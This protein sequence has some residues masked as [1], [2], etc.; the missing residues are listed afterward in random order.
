[1][2]RV[3]STVYCW[4]LVLICKVHTASYMMCSATAEIKN[5]AKKSCSVSAPKRTQE[6]AGFKK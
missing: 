3:N 1:M 4:K 6:T 2:G 5:S